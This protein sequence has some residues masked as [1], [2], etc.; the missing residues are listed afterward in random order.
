MSVLQPIKDA[1]RDGTVILTNDG[2]ARYVE[3]GSWDEPT[4]TGFYLCSPQ[5]E[6]P[7]CEK[8][9]I[10]IAF[11]IPKKWIPLPEWMQ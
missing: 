5:G 11:L 6:I 4:P 2:P 7:K 10:A 8:E 3:T 1:P 9:G